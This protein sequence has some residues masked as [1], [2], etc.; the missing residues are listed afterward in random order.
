M[1]GAHI[2]HYC[3]EEMQSMPYHNL[4]LAVCAY[5]SRTRIH[6][7]GAPFLAFLATF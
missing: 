6:T 4:S 5:S 1:A 2:R 3:T 7:S